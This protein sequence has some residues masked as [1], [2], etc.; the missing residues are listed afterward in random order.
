MGR[1]GESLPAKR[2]TAPA[3]G[4]LTWER[5]VVAE[6]GEEVRETWIEGRERDCSSEDSELSILFVWAVM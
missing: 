2:T 5:A 6:R 4:D 3:L 1:R